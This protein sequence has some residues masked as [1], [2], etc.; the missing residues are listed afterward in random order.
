MQFL[1]RRAIKR[2][3]NTLQHKVYLL[4]AYVVCYS[5]VFILHSTFL[6]A[7]PVSFFLSSYPHRPLLFGM[8]APF[9]A[10]LLT[11]GGWYGNATLAS[12]SWWPTLWREM[13]Y[14]WK[15]II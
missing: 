14:V 13:W 2:T 7:L 5:P 6:W 12:S 10:P 9:P 4:L 8:Q 11:S 3:M 1:L 15:P